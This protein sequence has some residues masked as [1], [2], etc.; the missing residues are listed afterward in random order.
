MLLKPY[1]LHTSQ[2]PVLPFWPLDWPF[3]PIL[4]HPPLHFSAAFVLSPQHRGLTVNGPIRPRARAQSRGFS[5]QLCPT[6]IESEDVNNKSAFGRYWS[7]L[8]WLPRPVTSTADCLFQA[9]SLK[10]HHAGIHL[11]AL[12]P[13]PINL[14]LLILARSPLFPFMIPSHPRSCDHVPLFGRNLLMHS[15]STTER[16]AALS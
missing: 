2:D 15:E 3:W 13:T 9:H 6:R 16:A 5:V 1:I 10:S 4:H 14:R 11:R 8:P 12:E 7:A